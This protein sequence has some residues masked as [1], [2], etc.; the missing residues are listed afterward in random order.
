LEQE[1]DYKVCCAIGP[2][3]IIAKGASD[4]GLFVRQP[5]PRFRKTSPS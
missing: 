5:C 2:Y 3:E 1:V 4:T